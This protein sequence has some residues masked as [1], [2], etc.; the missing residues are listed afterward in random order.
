MHHQGDPGRVTSNRRIA[1]LM[2]LEVVNEVHLLVRRAKQMIKERRDTETSEE[3][4]Y[5][6]SGVLVRWVHR[7]HGAH[8]R[9]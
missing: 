3:V 9:S 4:P 6:D 1:Y 2:E 8:K 7:G 5:L